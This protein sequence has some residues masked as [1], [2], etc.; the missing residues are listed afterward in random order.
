MQI[1]TLADTY[2]PFLSMDRKVGEREQRK[3]RR[4]GKS[5]EKETG[6][7]SEGMKVFSKIIKTEPIRS[8]FL[9]RGEIL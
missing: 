7:K 1:R 3:G 6:K 4:E 9:D 8:E 2:T 5:G